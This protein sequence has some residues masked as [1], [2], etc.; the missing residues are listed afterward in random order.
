MQGK[1]QHEMSMLPTK[2]Q[3]PKSQ[4]PMWQQ[5]NSGNDLRLYDVMTERKHGR[6]WKEAKIC[7][8]NSV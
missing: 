5:G 4:N 8:A 6:T 2:F 7:E 1:Q 3:E